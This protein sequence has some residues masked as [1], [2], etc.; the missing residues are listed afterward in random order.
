MKL[1]DAITDGI[2]HLEQNQMRAGLSILSICIGIANVLC[3]LAIGDG[4]KNHR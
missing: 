4:L 1:D 2:I 3:I